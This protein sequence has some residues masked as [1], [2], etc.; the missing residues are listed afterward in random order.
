MEIKDNVILVTSASD[1]LTRRQVPSR[2]Q[3][4]A[5]ARIV[6]TNTIVHQTTGIDITELLTSAVRDLA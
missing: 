6:I 3:A 4:A 5:P 1:E 2:T